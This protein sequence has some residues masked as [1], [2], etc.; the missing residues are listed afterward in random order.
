MQGNFNP[1]FCIIKSALGIPSIFPT[2]IP[3][4]DFYSEKHSGFMKKA[5]YFH[6]C[7]IWKVQSA[8]PTIMRMDPLSKRILVYS[9]P[10]LP[11]FSWRFFLALLSWIVP[12]A[13]ASEGLIFDTANKIDDIRVARCTR[14]SLPTLRLSQWGTLFKV[15]SMHTL[16]RLLR[17]LKCRPRIQVL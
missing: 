16:T 13:E 9:I 12:I 10:I 7:C 3:S 8:L 15:S 2:K 14:I 6:D 1:G 11:L 4:S 17:M 5:I